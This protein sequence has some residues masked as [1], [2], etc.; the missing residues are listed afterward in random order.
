[1]MSMHRLSAGNGYDYL[2]RQ[3]AVNDN[4]I[5]KGSPLADY[6]DEKGEAPGVWVGSGVQGID[7]MEEGDVVKAEQMD[8]LF[9]HG[10]HP[11]AAARLA[12]LGPDATE[13]DTRAAI[14]LGAPF[15]QSD[16][17]VN[18]FQAG[19]SKRYAEWNRAHGH[20]ASAMVSDEIR[21]TI[22]TALATDWFA[23]IEHRQPNARELAGFVARMTRPA[24]AVVSGWDLTFSP[25]KSVSALWA[26]ADRPT[27]LLIERAHE[28]AVNDALRFIEI[29][30]LKTRRGHAGVEQIDVTGLVA[31]AFT[32][33]DTRAGDPDLHTHVA[34]ANK[35]QSI[36][37][38]QWRAIDGR[39]LHKAI[40]AASETYNTALEAHLSDALGVRFAD[41]ARSDGK[42]AVREIVGLDPRLLELWSKRR[43]DI[44]RRAGELAR[45]FQEDHGRPPT[46][47]ERQDLHQT[48][49]IAT[50][51]AKHEPRS[52]NDQ[53]AMW[54]TQAD[55]LLGST[56]V[57]TMLRT[58]LAGRPVERPSFQ[59]AWFQ[60]AAAMV[61]AEVEDH[62]ADWQTWHIQA[63]AQRY[64]RGK[65]VAADQ[66]EATVATVV[67][68]A[69]A[70]CISLDPPESGVTEPAALR[71]ADGA[72][73]YRVTGSTRYTSQRILLA[74]HR[75]VGLAGQGDGRRC[76]PNSVEAALLGELAGGNPLNPGQAL[77]V[78]EMATS[79]CRVQLALAPAGTGKTTAMRVLSS[80][81]TYGGGSVVALAPSATAAAQLGETLGQ[82][83]KAETLHKLS[84]ELTR[85]DPP[86]WV[87]QID[88]RTL[89][90]VDEAGMADTLRL[91][92][93]IGW[94]I[95]RGGSVRLIGDDQQLGAVSAGGILRDIASTHGAVQL[96]EVMRFSDA[97]E[98]DASLALRDGDPA[99]LGFYLDND[100][101]HVGDTSTTSQQAFDRW[102]SDKH[103]GVDALMLAPTRE[104]AAE[105]NRQAREHRLRDS[106][107][108]HEATLADHN[109]A[110]VGDTVLTRLNDRRL[111]A[112]SGWVK[113]GDRWLVDHV[114][115]DG[116]LD[117]HDPRSHRRLTLPS[118]YVTRHVELGYASTIHGA[119]GLTAD[120]C[121]GILTGRE[122]RQQLYTM[123]SRGRHQN[124]VYVQVTGDGD[125]DTRFHPDSITPPTATER[126]ERVLARSDAPASASTQIA[127]LRDPRLQLGA[128]VACYQDAIVVAA[129]QHAGPGLINR[130][131]KAAE[132]TRLE[133]TDADAWPPLR[134]HLL[135]IH[136][137]GYDP[138]SALL[139]AAGEEGVDDARDPAA[140]ID[141]RLEVIGLRE[142]PERRPLPWLPGIPEQL[143]QNPEWR[144]Y[145]AS[146]HQLVR[147]LAHQVEQ[148]TERFVDIPRWAAAL[149][150]P[151]TPEV[152]AQV[153]LWRAAHQLPDTDLRPTGPEQHRLAEARVQQRL[154]SLIAGESEQ[155]LSW[156]RRIH[157]VAPALATDPGTIRLARECAAVDPN[158][159]KLLTV[160][161]DAAQRALPDDHKADALRFRLQRWL[162]P[163]WETV[164]PIKT[165]HYPEGELPRMR[166]PSPGMSI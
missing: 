134:S 149:I 28:A 17:K 113:N 72:S 128:A 145:L 41:F 142:A 101:V 105:L 126:L 110:S 162:H 77:L 66:L 112:G 58:V 166:P 73:V 125:P 115:R 36:V 97:T 147:R 121:H 31:A 138:L 8:A 22:R 74:E 98:A 151:P 38:G 157:A 50:R 10:Q 47:A 39:T 143:A 7:G 124:H 49:T 52:R 40:T 93:V 59:D 15:R 123:L 89:V 139:D 78:R 107:P 87:Q 100:R 165:T 155:V 127:E 160:V 26:L 131:E 114:H 76:D 154:D 25:V 33:R 43:H 3:V 85:S 1:M 133:L 144:S 86:A 120:T 116:S 19:L 146:R 159:E 29:Q 92:H 35:V 109:R 152:I 46:P 90:I 27:A 83:V 4:T 53:R 103:A 156:V 118:N 55:A 30:V 150:E 158:G 65:N 96:S 130:L 135:T 75:L 32:H 81:W 44:T 84:H 140:W 153:E 21:A 79:G 20:R 104:L 117:V 122:S 37:D 56:G 91:D 136:A 71:R 106:Q 95:A 24:S 119:Q 6:Y 82:G 13:R 2:T 14:R 11:L 62:R 111:R 63:E 18:V 69:L 61:V 88:D 132:S 148:R 9:G 23:A 34:V 48:A 51:E 64:V 54:R 42:R 94:V 129:E 99:C 102:L 67:A 137:N 70:Q 60:H 80:A 45:T 108:A 161:Q 12:V 57:I 68:A 163:V 141:H 5:A 16:P 164:E